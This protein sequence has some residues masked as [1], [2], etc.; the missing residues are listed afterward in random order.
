MAAAERPRSLEDLNPW[1]RW[2]I[3]LSYRDGRPA[4]TE[5][6]LWTLELSH[7]EAVERDGDQIHLYLDRTY[8]V[9]PRPDRAWMTL[10]PA[11]YH[12]RKAG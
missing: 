9:V 4:L 6:T 11:P 3:E 10:E 12:E 1:A 2:G 5:T 8:R 7:P